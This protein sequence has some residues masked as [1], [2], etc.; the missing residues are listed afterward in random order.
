MWD[1]SSK[2]GLREGETVSGLVSH[3]PVL[4]SEVAMVVVVLGG[5]GSSSSSSRRDASGMWLKASGCCLASFPFSVLL[6][7]GRHTGLSL[8]RRQAG[9]GAGQ[10]PPAHCSRLEGAGRSACPPTPMMGGSYCS[11]VAQL[12]HG[13]SA[14]SGPH[15]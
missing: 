14:G 13:L 7:K 4:C 12:P 6:G 10:G 11:A 1:R 5:M 2:P 15:L 8:L 3:E 9:P